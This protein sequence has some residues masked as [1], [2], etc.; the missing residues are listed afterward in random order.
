MPRVGF[1]WDPIGD[2]K[3]DHSRRLRHFLRRL[4]ERQRRTASGGSERTSLDRGL[5]VSGPGL[6]LAD[7]IQRT[8]SALCHATVC[9]TR[10]RSDCPIRHGAALLAELGLLDSTHLCERLTCWTCATSATRAHTCHA[11]SKPIPPST[12][13]AR[14]LTMPISATIRQLRRAQALARSRSVGLIADNNS[15]TYHALQVAFS[16]AATSQSF[17]SGFVLVVEESRLCFVAEHG[18][19]GADTGC[20]RKRSGAESVQSACGTWSVVIR[21]NA[22]FCFERH[23]RVCR[24]GK[25]RLV[26]RAIA[27]KWLAGKHH[28]EVIFRHAL[29][30]L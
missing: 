10:N 16:Q 19:L 5:P 15:S 29:H 3:T 7:P 23:I 9:A 24:A 11:S 18:G 12:A 30:R 14:Q 1:A 27:G 21:C 26:A 28:C 20:R 25:P 2:G 6:N 13:R 8:D 17:V 4:Y 22:S